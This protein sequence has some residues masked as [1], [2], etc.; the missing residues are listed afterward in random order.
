M[1]VFNFDCKFTWHLI[2]I[3]MVIVLSCINTIL[4]VC[5]QLIWIACTYNEQDT[6]TNLL[7]LIIKFTA[8]KDLD[9]RVLHWTWGLF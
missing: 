7:Y 9:A 3:C 1:I 4:F 8:Y 5:G 2:Y 6:L